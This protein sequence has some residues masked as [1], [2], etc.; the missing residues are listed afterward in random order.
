MWGSDCCEAQHN[1][2]MSQAKEESMSQGKEELTYLFSLESAHEQLP[3]FVTQQ[4]GDCAYLCM[5]PELLKI[6]V[7][8]MAKHKI[9]N[10]VVYLAASLLD[11]VNATS[12]ETAAFS[13][14]ELAVTCFVLAAKYIDGP[15]VFYQYNALQGIMVDTKCQASKLPLKHIISSWVDASDEALE[16]SK[17]LVQQTQFVVATM[18]DWRFNRATADRFLQ[19]HITQ[20]FSD[21]SF[22]AND[23]NM[24]EFLDWTIFFCEMTVMSNLCYTV[25][26]YIISVASIFAARRFLFD[27]KS[28]P[29]DFEEIYLVQDQQSILSCVTEILNIFQK[30]C[31]SNATEQL[32]SKAAVDMVS[33]SLYCTENLNDLHI[34]AH[35]EFAVGS[36]VATPLPAIA[37]VSTPPPSARLLSANFVW[38]SP[39]LWISPTAN[40][41]LRLSAVVAD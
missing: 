33:F 15:A 34:N 36:K 40:E 23:T 19:A 8:V 7:A 14:H 21:N 13:L 10:S 31:A 25:K 38:D 30:R 27:D 28:L 37:R 39:P 20:C 41:K 1:K 32:P 26:P 5:R 6:M 4:P 11:T 9:H 29:V 2:S 12:L 35:E 16:I 24:Q 22:S 17:T 3:H 18:L